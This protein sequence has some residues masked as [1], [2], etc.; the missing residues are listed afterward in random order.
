MKKVITA[1]F[2]V[3]V[4]YAVPAAAQGPV[5]MI[6]YAQCYADAFNWEYVC[7]V[8]MSDPDGLNTTR[9]TSSGTQPV[10]SP[11]GTRVAFVDGS[12]SDIVVLNLSDE[13]LSN[14]TNHPAQYGSPAWSP[15]GAQIAFASDR[16]GQLELY[17]M[18]ADGSGVRR[19]TFN[20]GF[21]GLPAWFRDGT[22]IAFDCEVDS[23]NT[24]ICAIKT[25]GTS[26]VR[27]TSDPGTDSGAAVSPADGRIAFSTTR[28]GAGPEIAILNADG[29][30]SRLAASAFGWQPTW[31][32]DGTHL[33]YVSTS[34]TYTGRCYFGDGAHNADDFCLPVNDLYVINADGTGTSRLGIGYDLDWRPT[35]A[36]LLLAPIA[37]ITS[38]C[39]GHTCSLDGSGSWDPDGAITNY[40]WSFGD[41]STGSGPTMSHTYATDG[42]YTL[43][44]TVYDNSG[45]TSSQSTTVNVD[46]PPVATFTSSC[47]GLACSFDASDAFDSGGGTIVSYAWFFGDGT[48]ASAALVGHTYAAFGTY[49]VVLRVTDNGGAVG[50]LAKSI[51]LT[52]PGVHV[53]DLD[54]TS[55]NEA[56]SWKATATIAVHDDS[57][58]PLTNA[59]VSGSWSTGGT[60][61]CTT[62]GSDRCAVSKSGI[63]KKTTSVTFTITSVARAAVVYKPGDNHDPDGDSNGTAITI[64][65]P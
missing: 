19:V 62:D 1:L 45:A 34:I 65:K 10:W 38:S 36:P 43:T 63:P 3:L 51:T 48:T 39:S 49:T 22:S 58:R 41:G 30:V 64:T 9:L 60:G 32:P 5:E 37:A 56:G 44:L 53:S 23:G 25:D 57:H 28:F 20:E 21:V 11:D 17:L 12:P 31:S 8:Y 42:A 4:A 54:G 40:S 55:T 18:N 47:S 46:L 26:L 14:L 29:A 7:G 61:T 27:L 50:E 2:G 33:A 59:T 16:D 24:D 35:L 15:D 6:V 52:Q 13:N